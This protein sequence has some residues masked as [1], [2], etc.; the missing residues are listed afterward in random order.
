VTGLAYIFT[1]IFTDTFR[2]DKNHFE[3]KTKKF[4]FFANTAFELIRSLLHKNFFYLIPFSK[5]S[6][7][8]T[9]LL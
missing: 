2:K 3:R 6:K 1:A 8:K 7:P 4:F 9:A 5:I